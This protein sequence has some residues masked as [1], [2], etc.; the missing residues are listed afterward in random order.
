M[1]LLRII[2]V[3]FFI[4]C[5]PL[6][7]VAN[8]ILIASGEFAPYTS[9]TLMNQG[10]ANHVITEAFKQEGY[11]AEFDYLPWKRTYLMTKKGKFPAASYYNEAQK[12]EKS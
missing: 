12:H 7:V 8:T 1:K 2:P 5:F 11:V 4:L 9:E 3:F 6:F 10:F